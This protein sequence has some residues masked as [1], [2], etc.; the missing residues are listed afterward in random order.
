MLAAPDEFSSD[1]FALLIAGKLS[2]NVPIV[3]VNNLKDDEFRYA[4]G[5]SIQNYYTSWLYTLNYYMHDM[6]GK[7]IE[8]N[9][10]DT[11]AYAVIS[12]SRSKQQELKFPS[13]FDLDL[14]KSIHT[15]LGLGIIDSCTVDIDS[16]LA[17]VTLVYEPS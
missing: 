11:G 4:Y 7:N 15:D 12:L 13:G 1:G 9:N 6:P 16:E 10:I 14:Y 3:T 2:G 5:A 8:Y 17:S